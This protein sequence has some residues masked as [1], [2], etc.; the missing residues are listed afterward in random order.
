MIHVYIAGPMRGSGTTHSDENIQAGIAAYR[1][2]LLAGHAPF[3][4][5]LNHYADPHY[6][7]LRVEHWLYFDR[8]WISRCQALIRL[9]GAS[10]GADQEVAWAREFGLPVFAD[11][12][13]FLAAYGGA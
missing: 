6:E 2:V 5:H 12:D 13:A 11:V 1:R 7:H 4:P 9:P 8:A 10:V 3:C